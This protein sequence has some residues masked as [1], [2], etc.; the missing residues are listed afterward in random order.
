MTIPTEQQLKEAWAEV[1]EL[2]REYLQVHEV[3]LPKEDS[4][5]AIWLATLRH[6]HPE[7]VHKDRIS[8]IVRRQRPDAATDQQV[9]H[10]SRKGWKLVTL[11][12]GEHKID[13]HHPSSD[14]AN[15]QARRRGRL[16]A[17]DFS[18]LKKV[19]GNRC[20]T[21][22]ATEGRPDPRYGDEAV[23]LQQGHQDPSGSS[24]LGNIIP[25]CQFC[26]RAYKDDF[27]FDAKG[28]VRAIASVEPVKRA[29][30]EVQAKVRQ[31]ASA[32]L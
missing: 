18:D 3:G 28:R 10:L 6:Y 32:E 26:N 31:W 20:A 21:C 25:Q 22:G 8:E 2:H 9:R 12:P 29:S 30:L 15:Q 16:Q 23:Q 4:N 17:E 24:D 5:Q 27:V 19:F 13:W 7:S 14:F 11:K 1:C